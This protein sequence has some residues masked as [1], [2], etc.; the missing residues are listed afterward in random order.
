MWLHI[1]V[2]KHSK[3]IGYCFHPSLYKKMSSVP[4][5]S[6]LL[7]LMSSVLILVLYIT[8][9]L[10]CVCVRACVLVWKGV[11]LLYKALFVASC[12]YEKF[13]LID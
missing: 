1:H 13:C 10:L 6:Q 9:L 8:K 4:V 7:F 3:S 5:F 2:D 11:V 12:L